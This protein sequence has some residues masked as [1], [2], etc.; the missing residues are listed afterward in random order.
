MPT[1]PVPFRIAWGVTV[2]ERHA[3]RFWY[4][5]MFHGFLAS[6]TEVATRVIARGFLGHVSFIVWSTNGNLARKGNPCAQH[7]TSAFYD[8]A[9][10]GTGPV[11][12]WMSGEACLRIWYV[13]MFCQFS[14]PP[15]TGAYL[16]NGK[17]FSSTCFMYRLLHQRHFCKEGQ[18]L[19]A[20]ENVCALSCFI[21]SYCLGRSTALYYGGQ[22]VHERTASRS[23][24]S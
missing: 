17:S 7:K 8:T 13:A 5:P 16:S 18:S 15:D 11:Q 14:S 21:M 12:W 4:V 10:S 20:T 3:S 19:F 9:W 22:T 6:R 1:N 24:M 23:G 2:H